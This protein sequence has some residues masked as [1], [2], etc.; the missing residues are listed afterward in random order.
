MKCPWK[1]PDLVNAGYE[2]RVK[3]SILESRSVA[4]CGD[5]GLKQMPDSEFCCRRLEDAWR[6]VLALWLEMLH[7]YE[8]LHNNIIIDSLPS[9][10]DLSNLHC[11]CIG[12]RYLFYDMGTASISFVALAF[13]SYISAYHATINSRPMRPLVS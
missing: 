4:I 12:Y 10:H 3:L 8:T 13:V 1:S 2:R 5:Y 7:A 11:S 9:L 6:G